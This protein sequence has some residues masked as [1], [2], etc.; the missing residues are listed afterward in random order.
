MQYITATLASIGV[1]VYG[2]AIALPHDESLPV[3]LPYSWLWWIVGPTGL[4]LIA[5]FITFGVSGRQ[6]P[7]SHRSA[8]RGGITVYTPWKDHAGVR[9]HRN[10]K[11][12]DRNLKWIS[13]GAKAGTLQQAAGGRWD[14]Y[15]EDDAHLGVVSSDSD[16]MKLVADS[17]R[18]A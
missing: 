2:A 1:V 12:G 11:T 7:K 4:L 10:L 18:E 14:V 17:R 3:L 6:R 13:N 16:G 15:D 5:S 8:T 9:S